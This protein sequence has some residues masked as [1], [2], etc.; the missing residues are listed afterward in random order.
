MFAVVWLTDSTPYSPLSFIPSSPDHPPPSTSGIETP[1]VRAKSAINLP[2]Q[3][4]K[5]RAAGWLRLIPILGFVHPFTL[6]G[7]RQN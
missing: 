1:T 5:H 4:A 3:I 6:L 2:Q 7:T